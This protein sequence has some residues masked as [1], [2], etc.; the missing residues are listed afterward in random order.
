MLSKHVLLSL[1][2][3]ALHMTT[4]VSAT[5]N[6]SGPAPPP[7]NPWRTNETYGWDCTACKSPFST[8]LDHASHP[9][10]E[11][12]CEFIQINDRHTANVWCCGNPDYKRQEALSFQ[13]SVPCMHNCQLLFLQA[14]GELEC[15]QR[16]CCASLTLI[17]PLLAAYDQ[18]SSLSTYQL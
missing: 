2:V 4:I 10:L 16:N 9:T 12:I 14:V 15:P 1:L 5:T 17:V 7:P 3:Y 6:S 11:L 18:R 8:S 13:R